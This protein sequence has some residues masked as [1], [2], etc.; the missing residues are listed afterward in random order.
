MEP[1]QFE[2]E[3]ERHENA[4]RLLAFFEHGEQ[5]STKTKII[6][7]VGVVSALSIIFFSFASLPPF[8]FPSDK[9]ITIASGTSL[10]EV[11]EILNDKNMI[12]SR[13]VFEFC[14][15]VVGGDKPILAGQYL[16]DE[17]ISACRIAFRIAHGISGIPLSR[18]TIPEGMSNKDIAQILASKLSDFDTKIFLEISKDKEG[19]LFPDTYFLSAVSTAQDVVSVMT[20]NFNKRTESLKN[21]MADAQRSLSDIVIMASIL[22]KEAT[23]EEDKATVAGILWKRISIGMALQVDATFM[24]LL[25]KRSDELTTEDLK[26]KSPY[27]TYTNR[28][29]PPG[30]IGNPGIVAMQ[31]AFKP[32]ASSY[33]YY[34]SDNDGVMHYAKTFEEHI[35]NKVKYLK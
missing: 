14:A 27:N 19:Y 24:Y 29:L 17:P 4:G 3:N 35:A 26:M 1:N 13:G 18:V 20:A 16:F 7:F 2:S 11:S 25:G 22:E 8:S 30:A 5:N 33:L 6:Y 32:T 15:K 12:R 31:A 10:S 34:L 28:G 23:S 9:V 21:E